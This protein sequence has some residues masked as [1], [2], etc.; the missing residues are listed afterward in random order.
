MDNGAVR[1]LSSKRRKNAL[2]PVKSKQKQLI[3]RRHE[4]PHPE[5]K[6][7]RVILAAPREAQT[8]VEVATGGL[9]TG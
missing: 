4:R 6:D 8:I 7:Y 1:I 3:Y 5:V 2:T 9:N